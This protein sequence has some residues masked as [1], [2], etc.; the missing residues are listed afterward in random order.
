[1]PLIG[2][3]AVAYWSEGAAERTEL[4]GLFIAHLLEHRWGTTI[5]TGWSDWDVEVHCHPWTL[6][7]VC[8]A[9]ED[10][11]GDKHLIRVRYRLE[12]TGFARVMAGLGLAGAA[13]AAGVSV[14]LAA[15][16]AGLVAVLLLAARWRGTRLAGRVVSGLDGLARGLGLIPCEGESPRDELQEFE[17]DR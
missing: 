15:L 12:L 1:L 3:R 14:G 7:R 2:S 16:G 8:T 13:V 9:Q 11:G 5:D 17:E 6:V 10:H 4:V